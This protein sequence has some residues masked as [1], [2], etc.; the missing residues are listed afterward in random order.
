M[1]SEVLV[2]QMEHECN[3]LFD[4]F[5]G[6][7]KDAMARTVQEKKAHLQMEQKELKRLF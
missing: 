3:E 6:S 5:S 1:A 7:Q 4:S 2:R